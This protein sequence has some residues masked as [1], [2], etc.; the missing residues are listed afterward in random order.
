[1]LHIETFLSNYEVDHDGVRDLLAQ[2]NVT[3]GKLTIGDTWDFLKSY[4]GVDINGMPSLSEILFDQDIRDIYR[5][6]YIRGETMCFV[7]PEVVGLRRNMSPDTDDRDLRKYH[8]I[9]FLSPVPA[10]ALDDA[11]WDDD[12]E[13]KR[14]DINWTL[15]HELR[16]VMQIHDQGRNGFMDSYQLAASVYD[17]DERPAEAQANDFAKKLS[18]SLQLASDQRKAPV[19]N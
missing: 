6:G 4:F 9:V 1:M 18:R 12:Q 14:A 3:E 11:A 13:R 8:Y 5:S 15:I 10:S 16:H 7:E 17:H 19:R 2:H